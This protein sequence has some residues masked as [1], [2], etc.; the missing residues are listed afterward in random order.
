MKNICLEKTQKDAIISAKRKRLKVM[1]IM[2]AVFV[3]V[4]SVFPKF[5]LGDHTSSML[6]HSTFAEQSESH[7]LSQPSGCAGAAQ[8]MTQRS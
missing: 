8:Q 6:D 5:F 4:L 2:A 7:A 1:P 3:A